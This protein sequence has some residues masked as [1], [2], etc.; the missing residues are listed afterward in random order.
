M[1]LGVG[2]LCCDSRQ[3]WAVDLFPTFAAKP[4]HKGFGLQRC[5]HTG[6]CASLCALHRTAPMSMRLSL[7]DVAYLLHHV[8]CV[9]SRVSRVCVVVN[10]SLHGAPSATRNVAKRNEV[11]HW[12]CQTEQQQ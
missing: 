12:H 5:A 10:A 1:T 3:Q 11:C 2:H 7:M 4:R 6:I 9:A 8:A